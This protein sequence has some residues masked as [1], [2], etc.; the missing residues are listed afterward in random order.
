MVDRDRSLIILLLDAEGQGSAIYAAARRAGHHP[1]LATGIDTA[2]L[3]LGTMVPDV[4]VVRSTSAQGDRDA[5]ARF[6][7]VAP[8]V[9]IRLL[10]PEGTLDS[11]LDAPGVPL[12]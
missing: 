11:A 10:S 5:I 7:A 9:P 2:V 1:V 3:V 6:A 12:N 8:D 4:I